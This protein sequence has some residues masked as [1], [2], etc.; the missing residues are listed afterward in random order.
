MVGVVLFESVVVELAGIL[1]MLGV[2]A[3][4]STALRRSAARSSRGGRSTRRCPALS[5]ISWIETALIG[6][7]LSGSR[8]DPR[9]FAGSPG[10]PVIHQWTAWLSY[11]SLTARP[12]GPARCRGRRCRRHLLRARHPACIG[13]PGLKLDLRRLEGNRSPIRG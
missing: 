5:S 8:I 13:W 9:V 10:L 11:S 3:G 2:M 1:R 4:S 12:R 7:A 6:T